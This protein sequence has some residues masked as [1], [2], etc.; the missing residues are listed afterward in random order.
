MTDEV[1]EYMIAEVDQNNNGKIGIEEFMT[2]MQGKY[3]QDIISANKMARNLESTLRMTDWVIA[4]N[5]QN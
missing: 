5:Y 2:M 1:I 3:D 4:E